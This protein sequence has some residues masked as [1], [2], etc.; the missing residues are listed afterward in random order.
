LFQ[1]FYLALLICY[2]ITLFGR[3]SAITDYYYIQLKLVIMGGVGDETT[4]Q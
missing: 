1:Y 4:N 3:I 2:R